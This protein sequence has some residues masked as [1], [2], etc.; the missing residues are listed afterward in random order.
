MPTSISNNRDAQSIFQKAAV[1]PS[2][3]GDVPDLYKGPRTQKPFFVP[4]KMKV[5]ANERCADRGNSPDVQV[6]YSWIS[7]HDGYSS[8]IGNTN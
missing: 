8:S 7:A 1:Q 6:P 2:Y 4:E 5:S 3:P